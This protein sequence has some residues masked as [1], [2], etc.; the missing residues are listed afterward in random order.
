M[1]LAGRV[2]IIT[3]A[4]QGIGAAI[5]KQFALEGAIVAALDQKFEVKEV[6]DKIVPLVAGLLLMF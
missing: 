3:G 4:A 6:C 1:R 5:A 2:A